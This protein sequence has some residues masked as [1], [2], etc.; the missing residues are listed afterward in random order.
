MSRDDIAS[1]LGVDEEKLDEIASGYLP[2]EEVA[3]RLRALAAS[4]PSGR[5]LRVPTKAVAVFIIA[6]ALFFAIFAVVFFSRSRGRAR[7]SAC[8]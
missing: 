4:P 1:A 7:A 2:D 3:D 8:T 5:V 6:D